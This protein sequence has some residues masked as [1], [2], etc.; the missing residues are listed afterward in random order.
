M[1]TCICAYREGV[2]QKVIYSFLSPPRLPRAQSLLGS[3]GPQ[4]RPEVRGRGLWTQWGRDWRGSPGSAWDLP[5]LG[6]G[7]G[8]HAACWWVQPP[9]PCKY[10]RLVGPDTRASPLHCRDTDLM[11]LS[12]ASA[13]LVTS[14][15]PRS[16]QRPS[17]FRASRAV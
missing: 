5:L 6:A 2:G 13:A 8:G 1:A 17:Y 11:A 7:R 10:A 15:R 12:S 4:L 3:A 14:R 9:P 16:A